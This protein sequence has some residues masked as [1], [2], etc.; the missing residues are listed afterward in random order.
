MSS[1]KLDIFLNIHVYIFKAKNTPNTLTLQRLA[2]MIRGEHPFYDPKTFNA[3]TVWKATSY[4]ALTCIGFDGVTTLTEEAAN[5]KRN[6]LWAT[7]LVCLF[8]GGVSA[9]EVYLGQLVWPDWRAFSNLE[10]AF[11]DICRRAGGGALFQA[12]AVTI[13]LHPS[14]AV[15]RASSQRH[16]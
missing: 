9:L 8:A 7:V 16:V 14:A 5:P 10:T 12:M 15:S 3:R 1:K 11:L 2:Q 4:A 6:V 13:I